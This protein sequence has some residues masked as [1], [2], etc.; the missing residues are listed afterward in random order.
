MAPLTAYPRSLML[1]NEALIFEIPVAY[2]AKEI[3]DKRF[4]LNLFCS[5]RL[6][7]LLLNGGRIGPLFK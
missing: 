1:H 5:R 7:P 2:K 6:F 4:R 3:G